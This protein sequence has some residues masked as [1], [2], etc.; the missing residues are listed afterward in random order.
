V[1]RRDPEA[2]KPYAGFELV[3]VPVV[4]RVGTARC[5]LGELAALEPGQVLPLDQAVGTPFDLLSRGVLLGQVEPVAAEEGVAVK[6][7]CAAEASD[8]PGD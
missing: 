3:P 4:V 5:T 7:V 2:W 8:E 1:D 6:L